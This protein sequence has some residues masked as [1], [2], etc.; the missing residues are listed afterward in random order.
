MKASQM[1]NADLLAEITDDE[2]TALL[3]ERER[4]TAEVIRL[5]GLLEL[6][7]DALAVNSRTIIETRLPQIGGAVN[8]DTDAGA[9]QIGYRFRTNPHLDQAMPWDEWR[10]VKN[11]SSR[12]GGQRVEIECTDGTLYDLARSWKVEVRR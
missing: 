4:L 8:Y 6:A 2:S 10:T 5:R 11:L 1:R 9:L 3:K 7:E 12:L